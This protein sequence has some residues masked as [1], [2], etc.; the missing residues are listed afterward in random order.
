[1]VGMPGWIG[2]ARSTRCAWSTRP[3]GS[4]CVFGNSSGAAFALDAVAAGV[5]ITKLAF[6]EAPFIVGD[7]RAPTPS[8][9]LDRLGELLS[10]DRPGDMVE[11]FMSAIIEMP[12]EMIAD[13]RQSPMWPGFEAV[14]HTLIY[15]AAFMQGTQTG[16][17]L[18]AER[19]TSVNAPA[20]VLDG[21][22]SQPWVHAGADAIA[23]QLPNAQRQTLP[24]QT[25]TVDP[26]V[27]GPVVGRFFGD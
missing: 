9:Y 19:W 4:A 23:Q 7:S 26:D 1:M 18:P 3:G 14:A 24:D 6:Y 10:E 8:D 16:K 5:A 12:G 27:L 17:P 20:L 25:H 11:L 22:D 2:P 13:M 21:G 15:D